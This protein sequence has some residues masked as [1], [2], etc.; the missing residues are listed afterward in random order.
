MT[1]IKQEHFSKSEALAHWEA[2]PD[3]PSIALTPISTKHK[4]STY[5]QDG[6]RIVGSR[7][8][9]DSV[10]ANLKGFMDWENDTSRLE[11]LYTQTRERTRDEETG[12]I[13]NG[14]LT[15]AW[16][17]Y[18]RVKDRGRGNGKPRRKYN[19]D[20]IPSDGTEDD[21]QEAFPSTPATPG[22][23]KKIPV[24]KTPKEEPDYKAVNAGFAIRER[25]RT[26]AKAK[27]GPIGS[28][29]KP[30]FAIGTPDDE[31]DCGF[32]WTEHE[33]GDMPMTTYAEESACK[34]ACSQLKKEF[35]FKKQDLK[36]VKVW[37]D[38]KG[39]LHCNS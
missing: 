6:I 29:D 4:G 2:L 33:G 21:A 17:C 18:I 19:E 8:Y 5:A 23:I 13:I 9:I 12:K 39:K 37:K 11:I 28:K 15:G 3:H 27:S 1:D 22:P 35:A 25:Q 38:S 20:L 30:L 36:V 14:N 26:A 16:A 24:F 10:L 34:S 31:E 32:A 7:E